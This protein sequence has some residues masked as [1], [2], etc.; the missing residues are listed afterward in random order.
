MTT[1]SKVLYY[2]V[3]AGVMVL[4]CPIGTHGARCPGVMRIPVTLKE[5]AKIRQSLIARFSCKHHENTK[6]II[7]S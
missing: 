3:Q 5:V 4:V 6:I 1:Q 2:P 7:H